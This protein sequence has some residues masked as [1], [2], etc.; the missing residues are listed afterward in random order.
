MKQKGFNEAFVT[1]KRHRKVQKIEASLSKAR[2]AI[3]EA[4]LVRNLTSTQQDP[5]Y[6]PWGP[7][8]RNANAFHR[9]HISYMLMF[10]PYTSNVTE[11]AQNSV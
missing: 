3:R 1:S 2:S 8:Y 11:L 7:I 9:Y 10:I 5:D 4:A 6:V